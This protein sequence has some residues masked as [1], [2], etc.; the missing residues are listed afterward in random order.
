MRWALLKISLVALACSSWIFTSFVLE[1]RPLEIEWA[2]N[3]SVVKDPLASLM[4]LPASLPGVHA[5]L[6]KLLGAGGLK[7]VEPIRMDVVRLPCW[8]ASESA[9]QPVSA[10]WVRLTGRPCATD[11]AP[12]SI[13]V[14][15]LTNGYAGT[16]FGSEVNLMTTDF[17]PLQSGTNEIWMRFG[18]ND[19][20]ALES[21]FVLFKAEAD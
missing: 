9:E 10:R 13:E 11:A 8:D 2:E 17:M 12:E 14:R 1:T 16:V 6:P 5:Q 7:A 19:G 4:R 3:S 20:V 15:N 21:R 18:F